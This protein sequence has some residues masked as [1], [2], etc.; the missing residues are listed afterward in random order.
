MTGKSPHVITFQLLPIRSNKQKTD[1]NLG[2]EEM[3]WQSCV[4]KFVCGKVLCV[5]KRLCVKE[6]WVKEYGVKELCEMVMCV[7]ESK[8]FVWKS[9]AWKCCVCVWKS[10]VWQCC[11]CVTCGVW[12][13]F[14]CVKELCVWRS[15]VVVWESCV[16]V[17][18]ARSSSCGQESPNPNQ[19]LFWYIQRGVQHLWHTARTEA[20]A[21]GETGRLITTLYLHN[22]HLTCWTSCPS[23]L[24]CIISFQFCHVRA[25]T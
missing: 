2:W 10:G 1:V 13:C 17:C 19:W 18:E 14:V 5:C 21:I 9:G 6:M 20:V 12:Q 8:S 23:P 25:F 22:F 24:F 15:C 16:C 7:C 11:V 4:W 3:V